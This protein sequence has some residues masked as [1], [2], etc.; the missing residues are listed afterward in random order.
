MEERGNVAKGVLAR[1]LSKAKK[2]YND[3]TR[4]PF[5]MG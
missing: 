3:D 4:H 2:V 1:F 5:L